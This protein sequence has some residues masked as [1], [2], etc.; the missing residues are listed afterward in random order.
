M[1]VSGRSYAAYLRVYEPVGAF[2]PA[3]QE[4][5]EAY[6]AARGAPD[7]A[8]GTALEHAAGLTALLTGNVLPAG[9]DGGFLQHVDGRLY[10][11]PWGIR[12]RGEAAL[13]SFLAD[14][15]I[16]IVDCFLPRPAVEAVQFRARQRRTTGQPPPA[17]HILMATWQVPLRWFVLF[18]PDERSLV[19]DSRAGS[20]GGSRALRSLTYTTAMSRARQRLARSLS[21]LR[22]SMPGSAATEGV[23]E[24]GRW[25]ENFHPHSLVELDYGGLVQL[26]D[27]ASLKADTSAGDLA[28]AVQCLQDGDQPAAAA[29]YQRV[30]ERWQKVAIWESAN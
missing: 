18:R 30:V 26:C 24:L 5:W 29:V 14:L 9:P 22:R 11:C 4:R 8:T 28:T 7:R 3:D 17:P 13:A 16:E 27:D 19:L 12:M 25:L 23:Q 15:P 21:A 1:T 2:P 20:V 6:A 10:V